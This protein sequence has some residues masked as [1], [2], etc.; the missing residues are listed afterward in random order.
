ML[1]FQS[2]SSYPISSTPLPV[3]F[4]RLTIYNIHIGHKFINTRRSESYLKFFRT[5]LICLLIV[6]FILYKQGNEQVVTSVHSIAD[7]LRSYSE[8]VTKRPE[9]PNII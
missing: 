7:S 4:P 2:P 8:S 5:L 3:P 1:T 6:G 9:V